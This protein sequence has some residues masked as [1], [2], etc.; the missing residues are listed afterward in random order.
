LSFTEA[1]YSFRIVNAGGRNDVRDLLC[2]CHRDGAFTARVCALKGA[3]A[4]GESN[5]L[6]L[7]LLT[8]EWPKT[9]RFLPYLLVAI[10]IREAGKAIHADFALSLPDENPK[11]SL[12]PYFASTGICWKRNT[13]VADWP[14][15]ASSRRFRDR[16]SA[17]VEGMHLPW[18]RA[19][20]TVG[21]LS[22]AVQGR[23][24]AR[25]GATRISWDSFIRQFAL[26]LDRRDWR[27][28]G[29]QANW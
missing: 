28:P 11:D 4:V 27:W 14:S 1:G 19:I 26:V 18:L 17:V 21:V 20:H 15:A 12:T 13:S 9:N 6:G 16:Y 24:S 3:E 2:H 23:R 22:P 25:H 7:Y 10:V 5:A 8:R 29:Q